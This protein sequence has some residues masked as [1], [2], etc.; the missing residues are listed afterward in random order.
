MDGIYIARNEREIETA[1][2]QIIEEGDPLKVKRESIREE[3]SNKF[4]G[5]IDRILQTIEIDFTS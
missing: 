5:T 2:H 4:R 3:F 1:L